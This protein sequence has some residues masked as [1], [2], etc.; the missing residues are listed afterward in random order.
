MYDQCYGTPIGFFSSQW[1]TSLWPG[2]MPNL[3]DVKSGIKHNALSTLWQAPLQMAT[4]FL[5]TSLQ[6]AEED[7]A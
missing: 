6:K 3:A 1:P 2:G 7:I 4:L 5:D